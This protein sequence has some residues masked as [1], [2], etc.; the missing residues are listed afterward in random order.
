MI[1]PNVIKSPQTSWTKVAIVSKPRRTLEG[2]VAAFFCEVWEK[3]R[4]VETGVL[5]SYKNI[6]RSC[7]LLIPV[8]TPVFP[9]NHLLQLSYTAE[10]TFKSYNRFSRGWIVRFCPYF[11]TF[12]IET[13]F[14]YIETFS[15]NHFFLL[16]LYKTHTYHNVCGPSKH[17]TRNKL[18]SI[19]NITQKA[20][21]NHCQ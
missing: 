20:K 10:M 12:W 2:R 8:V 5:I 17:L 11:K 1:N 6:T 3:A 18:T 21:R 15:K 4:N 19:K 13:I 16:Y 9:M 7:S 14:F